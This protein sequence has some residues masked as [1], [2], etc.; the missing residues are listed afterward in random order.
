MHRGFKTDSEEALCALSGELSKTKKPLRITGHSLGA[1][2]AILTAVNLKRL[3]KPIDSVTLFGCPRISNSDFFQ[4]FKNFG[5]KCLVVRN[6]DDIVTKLPP[7]FIFK[8]YSDLI[9]PTIVFEKD[10][11]LRRLNFLRGHYHSSYKERLLK[12]KIGE[13][14]G[15]G[16][17]VTV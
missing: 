5:I 12:Y 1:A 9:L 10:T 16:Q 6:K 2:T 14:H 15:T 11:F 3:G 13:C 7:K 8:S 17:F 4:F